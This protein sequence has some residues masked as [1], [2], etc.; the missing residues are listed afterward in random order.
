M[1]VLYYLSLKTQQV[2]MAEKNSKLIFIFSEMKPLASY[3][4]ESQH[5][6]HKTI[7]LNNGLG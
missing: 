4:L 1:T 5:D 3:N 7:C 2:L 6:F